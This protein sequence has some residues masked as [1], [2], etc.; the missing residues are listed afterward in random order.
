MK[1]TCEL[2]DIIQP[3][4]HASK[5]TQKGSKTA[6]TIQIRAENGRLAFCAQNWVSGGRFYA[7][8]V[9]QQDGECSINGA[10]FQSF[11]AAH[12]NDE[13]VEFRTTEKNALI[14][15]GGGNA[16]LALEARSL[17]VGSDS[18]LEK[19]TT[20]ESTSFLALLGVSQFTDS[21]A[22][23]TIFSGVYIELKDGKLYALGGQRAVFSYMW[24]DNVEGANF[25]ILL[26]NLFAQL[27]ASIIPAGKLITLRSDGRRVG[28]VLENGDYFYSNSLSGEYPVATI[29]DMGVGNRP[30]DEQSI[31]INADRLSVALNSVL[32][33]SRFGNDANYRRTTL[34]VENG[35]LCVESYEG[36]EIGKI[37]HEISLIENGDPFEIILDAQYISSVVRALEKASKN[38]LLA[39]AEEH[40]KVPVVRIGLGLPHMAYIW[41]E[42]NSLF[43]IATMNKK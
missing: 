9:P 27:A 35:L 10:A 18:E 17:H 11:C 36:N 41:G 5:F 28:A 21:D 25:H 37:T 4:N 42:Q 30:S 1:F 8:V 31:A 24:I 40:K 34:K 38:P 26:H 6:D 2:S 33:I 16:R 23:G 39:W 20:V 7:D 43:M 29:V 12:R 14:S 15:I 13:T 3:L 19:I 22:V 32:G